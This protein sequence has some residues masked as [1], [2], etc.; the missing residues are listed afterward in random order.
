[1][2][3]KPPNELLAIPVLIC[4]ISRTFFLTGI[5][6]HLGVI[7]C[8]YY[9]SVV[10]LPRCKHNLL[11]NSIILL[12][13]CWISKIIFLTYINVHLCLE[14]NKYS[15]FNSQRNSTK[16]HKRTKPPKVLQVGNPGWAH[17]INPL[18]T[19]YKYTIMTVWS[20]HRGSQKPRF[21]RI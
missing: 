4:W 9:S 2:L 11:A 7:L 1:M 14:H 6:S 10:P 3:T 19:Q 13:V 12:F 16:N 8:K 15:S 20:N 17:E 5:N 18:K 21:S